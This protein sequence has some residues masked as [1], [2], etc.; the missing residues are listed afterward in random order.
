LNF[1]Y[2]IR[3]GDFLLQIIFYFSQRL[4]L[5]CSVAV[6]FATCGNLA[7]PMVDINDEFSERMGVMHGVMQEVMHILYYTFTVSILQPMSLGHRNS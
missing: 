5:L 7:V 3:R 6:I 4:L 1:Y 2:S